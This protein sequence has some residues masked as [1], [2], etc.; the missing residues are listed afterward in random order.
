MEGG[1]T[2]H[3]QRQSRHLAHG[4]EGGVALCRFY[5]VRAATYR[6]KRKR[7]EKEKRFV[8]VWFR[9]LATDWFSLRQPELKSVPFV[10]RTSSHGRMIITAA[11]LAAE[12]QG[13]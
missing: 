1:I 6:N 10:L 5:P 2:A 9:H 4:M 3:A 12:Q 8:S 13:I 7:D 11:N